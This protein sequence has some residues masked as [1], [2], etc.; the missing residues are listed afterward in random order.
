MSEL[1]FPG[2][3]RKPIP[4]GS[5]DPFITPVGDVFHIAVTES[6]TLYSTFTDG[7]GI[8]STGYIRRDGS[9]EQ[10][11]PVNIECDA[12][13][14]GNSWISGG[15]RVGLNSWESQGM[16]D[17]EWTPEQ[18]ATIKAIIRW[19]HEN[20]G[21]P[22]RVCPSPNSGGVGYHRLFNA[23]NKNAHS[24]PGDDRVRQ[25]NN[26]IVPW[27]NA[28]TPEGD[29]F[30]MT[31]ES[32]L[33]RI[34]REEVGNA[35]IVVDP[36]SPGSTDDEV[37]TLNGVLRRLLNDE[38]NIKAVVRAQADAVR[39]AIIA[40]LPPGTVDGTITVVEVQAAVEAGI[41]RVL[42]GLDGQGAP[43]R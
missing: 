12:Q 2:A 21:T 7:R 26:I 28:G 17:G 36:K 33:R 9:V 11:R 20:F 32:D 16:G 23:W 40:S 29:W 14:D 24:C 3:E 41:R 34:I 6:R 22:L 15:S 19:K 10:Y 1:W 30:D 4:Q 13:G 38:A 18:I 31:T 39:N 8:E 35:Q 5:N 43:T 37:L 27:L 25:F 42:G